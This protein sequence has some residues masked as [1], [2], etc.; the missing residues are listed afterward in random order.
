MKRKKMSEMEWFVIY[1]G[2]LILF[3]LIMVLNKC[4]FGSHKS[5]SI[6]YIICGLF[7]V[8]ILIL[9]FIWKKEVVEN[10]N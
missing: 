1:Q 9:Y 6:C 7:C 10:E 4:Y 3:L 8:F 2:F 5:G